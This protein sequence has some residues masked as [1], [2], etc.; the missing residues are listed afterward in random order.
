V[1][2]H[3]VDRL[4][5]EAQQ[6]VKLTSTNRSI[7]LIPLPRA[8]FLWELRSVGKA[9]TPHAAIRRSLD[10]KIFGAIARLILCAVIWKLVSVTSDAARNWNFYIVSVFDW[11]GGY[12]EGPAPDPIPNSAVK[13]LSADGTAS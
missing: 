6:C 13:T 4:E 8:G 9:R 5:V 12:G 11:P 10:L 7:G 1:E 3:H 2:D